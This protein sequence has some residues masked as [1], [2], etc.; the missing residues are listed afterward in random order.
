MTRE[1]ER[2]AKEL[3]EE[4]GRLDRDGRQQ[5]AIDTY[6][7]ALEQ[8]PDPPYESHL[9]MIALCSIGELNFLHGKLESAFEDFSEAVKCKGGLGNPHIHMRLGQLRFQRGE[10]N[11]ATDEFMRV[12]MASGEQFFQGEDRKYF[13]LIREYVNPATSTLK[14][15]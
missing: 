4:A 1:E 13:Q 2:R 15:N 8:L 9:A 10:L 6:E 3:I 12:Y 11:R 14:Q 7:R 5:A